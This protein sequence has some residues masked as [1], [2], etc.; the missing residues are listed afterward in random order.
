M[1]ALKNIALSYSKYNVLLY[2]FIQTC[3]LN[4]SPL[5]GGITLFFT[6]NIFVMQYIQP[7]S[8]LFSWRQ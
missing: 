5:L 4:K 8:S 7:S 1:Y 3:Y 6:K 2:L